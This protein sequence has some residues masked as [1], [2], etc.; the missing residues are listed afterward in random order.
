MP[1]RFGPCYDI[2]TLPA[3]VRGSRSWAG[4]SLA[5][6]APHSPR[7][8]ASG[9]AL[10]GLAAAVAACSASGGTARTVPRTTPN[11]QTALF[12]YSTAGGLSG[13]LK[14]I[15]NGAAVPG[16]ARN[17]IAVNAAGDVYELSGPSLNA[18]ATQVLEFSLN[19]TSGSPIGSFSDP[20]TAFQT[21][22]SIAVGPGGQIAVPVIE[23]NTA[24]VYTAGANGSNVC[25]I[26]A[27]S[28][29][30]AATLNVRGVAFGADGKTLY[31]TSCDTDSVSVY[32][33]G[34]SPASRSIVGKLTKLAC[35]FA[36]ALDAA[37]T[38]YVADVNGISVFAASASGNVVPVR[39]I[40]FEQNEASV[41][42][43]V[44]DVAIGRGPIG[45]ATTSASR[46]GARAPATHVS[47]TRAS[48]GGARSSRFAASRRGGGAI[49]VLEENARRAA[50]AKLLP[51]GQ[52]IPPARYRSP[53][54][55]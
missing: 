21:P 22:S 17:R 1:P 51:P 33:N 53:L 10:L 23:A 13:P 16:Y 52:A 29:Y 7:G 3:A 46:R 31:A 34:T 43:A 20:Q 41:G 30:T 4:G 42:F 32:G 54:C 40:R 11:G 24:Y 25:P 5:F 50:W 14:T 6:V 35:P 2:L 12:V 45:A 19:G 18:A 9:L 27:Y 55:R 15:P 28:D 8:A 39:R 37:G 47:A 44:A 26:A 48:G 38:I 36:L 49:C